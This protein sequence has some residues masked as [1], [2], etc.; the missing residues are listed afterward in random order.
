M[1]KTARAWWAEEDDLARFVTDRGKIEKPRPSARKS[2]FVPPKPKPGKPCE[3]STFTTKDASEEDLQNA[4]GHVA[5]GKGRTVHGA[6]VVPRSKFLAEGLDLIPG[7]PVFGSSVHTNVRAWPGGDGGD[8]A[9]KEIAARLGKAAK[10]LPL[11]SEVPVAGAG[12]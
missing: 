10:I 4:A 5:R 11:V 2:V 12:D 1:P 6:M 7:C 3:I 8:N 9:R